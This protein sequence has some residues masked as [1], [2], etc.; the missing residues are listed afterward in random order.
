MCR[1]LFAAFIIFIAG[2]IFAHWITISFFALLLAASFIITLLL[3]LRKKHRG[4]FC[5]SIGILIFIL[6]AASYINFNALSS[7]HI[8][9]AGLAMTKKYY[10]K[11]TIVSPPEYK[12]GLWNNRR[13][14]FDLKVSGYKDKNSWLKAEGL[15]RLNI[16]ESRSDYYYGDEVVVLG[17]LKAPRAP[18]NPGE[19]NY[20]EYLRRNKIYTLIEAKSDDEIVSLKADK[21]ILGKGLIFKIR[22]DIEKLVNRYF[23]VQDAAILNAVF[24]GKR[25]DISADL[26]EKFIRTGTA[27]ILAGQYTK[28]PAFAF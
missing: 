19:F 16:R 21:P 7:N 3:I 13:A 20:A 12:W 23:P 1:P 9:K 8:S 6:G 2:I 17:S 22:E 4:V 26:N 14:S 11:G 24:I 10:I 15:S 18:S 5:I 28:L 25:S 27:H